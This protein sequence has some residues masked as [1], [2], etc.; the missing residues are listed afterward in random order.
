MN[1]KDF[2]LEEEILFQDVEIFGNDYEHSYNVTCYDGYAIGDLID[3]EDDA[4]KHIRL[5]YP[6][7]KEVIRDEDKSNYVL[8]YRGLWDL[9]IESIN[10]GD[11][12]ISL[13]DIVEVYN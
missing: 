9:G 10:Y 5:E 6:K 13:G 3:E 4:P 11:I 1:N 8:R 2:I 12:M 7:I